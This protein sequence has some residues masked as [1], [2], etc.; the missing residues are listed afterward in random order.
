V[1][2]IKDENGLSWDTLGEVDEAF[3]RYFSYLFTKG[4]D[5]DIESCIQPI[6]SCVSDEMNLALEKDVTGE[7]IDVALF[8]M[9]PLKAPGPD[10]LNASF[11]Q[12]NWPTMREEVCDLMQG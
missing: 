9:A 1:G 12:N 11:F 6:E 8:Q 3:V 2:C 7:E 4:P 5:G 10:G